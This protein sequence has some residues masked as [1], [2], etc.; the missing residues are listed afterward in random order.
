MTDPAAT[1]VQ[2]S[3]P[4]LGWLGIMRLG[5]VQACIGSMVVLA[6]STMNRV[7]VV[8]WGVP[9]LL[10]GVLIAWHYLIQIIRPRF[11][12]GSDQGGRRTP[13]ILGGILVLTLGGIGAACATALMG[14]Q[15]IA[16][17]LL[18]IGAYTTIGIGVGASGTSLL[19]LLAKR[20]SPMRRPAAATIV[21]LMMIF[22]FVLTA[23]LAGKF[24]DPFSPERL[25][26]VTATVGI[27]ICLLTVLALWRIE[28]EG[29]L[30]SPQEPAKS[31]QHFR[32]A[33]AE[34]WAEPA[35]RR[36]TIF[37]FT[38]MLA[39]SAQELVFEPFAGSV[40]GLT[41]GESTQL[42]GLQHG[43]ALSGMI[44][45][46]FAGARIGTMSGWIMSGCFASALG[47]CA[48]ALAGIAGSMFDIRPI[49][50]L[51][52]FA[53]G[54]FAVSAIGMM[55]RL[56]GTGTPGREGMRMGIW[57]GAQA[58]AFA[59]GGLAGT[60]ASDLARGIFGAPDLAYASV[61]FAQ[62]LLFI[63][64]ALQARQLDAQ[65]ASPNRG[66]S[67]GLIPATAKSGRGD[68]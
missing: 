13:W 46:A 37:I 12:H 59:F 26:M 30:V 15:F 65:P 60:G 23:G 11:G 27:I 22:G 57:G 41:P 9:A 24:L 67:F 61:F 52:G 8:E 54:T 44:L 58:V 1:T 63:I 5:L 29:L 33:L 50:F 34:V 40:L 49:V 25:V 66:R 31:G 43:G 62:A 55:M 36:L 56:A 3:Q 38:S 21:W 2:P 28:S 64:A 19:A 32:D 53:N 47:L 51:L 6:T 18:A 20:V 10:P 45:V 42:T 16:G 17:V 68:G 7:M 4:D 35:A 14:S 48:L 39:Y